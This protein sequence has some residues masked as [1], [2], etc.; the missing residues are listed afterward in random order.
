MALMAGLSL[1]MPPIS[2][3][4]CPSLHRRILPEMVPLGGTNRSTAW[5][6]TLLP[7]PDSPTRPRVFPRSMEKLTPLTALRIPSSVVNST[8]KSCISSTSLPMGT[9]LYL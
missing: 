5:E 4:S 9:L 3:A 6:V 8:F 2:T 7:Q 1:S